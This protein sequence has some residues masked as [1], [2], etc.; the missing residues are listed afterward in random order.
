VCA[1]G[2]GPGDRLA[3]SETRGANR[4]SER[5][6]R[7][8]RRRCAAGRWGLAHAVLMAD[9]GRCLSGV[10]IIIVREPSREP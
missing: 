10:N 5:K 9:V 4:G 2:V 3:H 7:L 6:G 8:C 1:V